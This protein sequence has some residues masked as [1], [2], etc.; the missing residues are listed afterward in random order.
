MLHHHLLKRIYSGAFEPYVLF[1]YGAW[2]HKLKYKQIKRT[3][4]IIQRRPLVKILKAYRTTSTHAL[5]ILAGILP[6]HLR[7]KELFANFLIKT[8]KLQVKLNDTV[9]EPDIYEPSLN[10]YEQ[11]PCEW[12]TYP[13][14]KTPPSGDGIEIYTDGSKIDNKVGSAIACYYFNKLI[15]IDS[16]RLEDHAT[17][18]QAEAYAFFMA[19]DYIEKTNSWS[20]ASIF[21]DSLS[22][23]TALASPKRKTWILKQLMEKIKI[24]NTNHRPSFFWVK[25]HIRVA[26]NEEADKQAKLATR[27]NTVSLY[28]SKHN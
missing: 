22:L 1:G 10:P 5:Q 11:H 21:S 23:L 2:G 26:G 17:V 15:R 25:A 4:E 28:S 13:F 6:L 20:N 16:H 24:V 7:A 14:R 8:Q 12:T 19:L 18:F 9:F 27:K 3:F